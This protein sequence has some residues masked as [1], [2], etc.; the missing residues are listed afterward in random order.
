MWLGPILT[1][2]LVRTHGH[3]VIFMPCR[4]IMSSEASFKTPAVLLIFLLLSPLQTAAI[5]SSLHNRCVFV[6]ETQY[7]YY[8][9]ADTPFNTTYC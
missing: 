1:L 8:L 6:S 9:S 5:N 2:D 3:R 4:R 7:S